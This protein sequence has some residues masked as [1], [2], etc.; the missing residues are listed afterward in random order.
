MTNYSFKEKL[1]RDLINNFP[2][3][4]RGARAR[5]T[6]ATLSK[7]LGVTNNVLVRFLAE[8]H[9][10]LGITDPHKHHAKIILWHP[11]AGHTMEEEIGAELKVFFQEHPELSKAPPKSVSR[12]FAPAK[13]EEDNVSIQKNLLESTPVLQSSLFNP[14]PPLGNPAPSPILP[15]PQQKIKSLLCRLKERLV[16]KINRLVLKTRFFRTSR[17]QRHNSNEPSQ[18][19]S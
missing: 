10:E 5:Q 13:S 18:F 12:K 16:E 4:V 6:T 9:P 14:E 8:K 2:F 3:A 15:T 17:K 1:A 19:K 7:R 11:E